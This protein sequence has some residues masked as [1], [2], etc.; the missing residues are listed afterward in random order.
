M[1]ENKDRQGQDAGYNDLYTEL[2]RYC[3]GDH[4]PYHMPGHK[5]N[6]EAGPMARYYEIDI[7]EIDGFDDLH[8]AQGILKEA[9]ERANRLYGGSETETFYLVNGSTCGI[10]ASIMTVAERGEEILVARNCHKS[11]YHAAILQEL[12]LQYYHP[13][14]IEEYGICGGVNAEE[15]AYLL[16]QHT[17]C[18]AVVIT[19]PTYVGIL[20]DVRAVADVVHGQNKI[21]IVDAAHGAH[22]GLDGK[23]PPGA[24]SCGADLVIHS[25][26]K[27]LPAMTQTALLHVQGTRVDRDRL[28]KYLR[29]LQTSSPSYVLMASMDTCIRYVESHGAERCM[30]MRQ[31]YDIFC[32]KLDKCKHIRIGRIPH[33]KT[34]KDEESASTL[35]GRQER[36]SSIERKY[37]IAAWDIGKILLYTWD[38]SLH[39][40]QLY[41]LLREE[42]HLQMEMAAE[43]Y[44]LAI[45][46]IMD[47]QEGWQRLADALRQIDD[48]I[49]T[50]N[51]AIP[52]RT[53]DEERDA[54][55][56]SF[57]SITAGM[58]R[59]REK[60]GRSEGG[61]TAHNK[62]S[63]TA[64]QAYLGERMQ[65]PLAECTGKV[66]AEFINLYPP[67][68]PLV[69]PGEIISD[70][71]PELIRKY[72]SMGLQVQGLQLSY[73]HSA[74]CSRE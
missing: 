22:L 51:I 16:R 37:H 60:T 56:D 28:H 27:T 6:G 9:Q 64:A 49:E 47:T 31:E 54:E 74:R 65:V 57:V 4:Y 15:I 18:K 45:M 11:V 46:T 33:E 24:V 19:S 55:T 26:H 10:L 13:A 39:G 48:R 14:V 66:A 23:Q 52:E 71:L 67:G 36:S 5:R 43:K 69:V 7:T 35:S 21:L 50:G 63:M 12:E 68:I 2:T 34:R 29:M 32:K 70:E 53:P 25:L 30:F 62:G 8:L 1:Q 44:V 40:R 59:E 61:P 17:D 42:Y 73:N 72:Q 58:D 3:A 20:S 41:D 38:G